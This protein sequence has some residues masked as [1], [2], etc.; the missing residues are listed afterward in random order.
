MIKVGGSYVFT[1]G[2]KIYPEALKVGKIYEWTIGAEP[3][4]VRYLGLSKDLNIK[5]SS[6]I[7]SDKYKFQFVGPFRNDDY[8]GLSGTAVMQGYVV[9]VKN[10]EE[11]IK[12]QTL[13]EIKD[14]EKAIRK[15]K[16]DKDKDQ[17]DRLTLLLDIYKSFYKEK[18]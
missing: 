11:L 3:K 8:V 16:R 10:I 18:L 15:A 13:S 12:E 6:S 1:S 4:Y 17:V 14:Y 2:F 5:S 9:Q 7:G